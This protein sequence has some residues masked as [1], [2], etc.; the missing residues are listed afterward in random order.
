MFKFLQTESFSMLFSFILGLGCMA[1]LKPACKGNCSIQKAP[2][3]TEVKSSTYQLGSSC[4]QFQAEPIE[5]PSTGVI[6]PFERF[7][8]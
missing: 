3:Y 4:Y 8:R 2:P 7:L 6:E 1:V 5:C